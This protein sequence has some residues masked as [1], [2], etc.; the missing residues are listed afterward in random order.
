MSALHVLAPEI[1]L[2][3][4]CVVWHINRAGIY[5]QDARRRR[6]S[7]P[8]PPTPRSRAP[9]AFSESERQAQIGRAHV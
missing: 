8:R 2:A 4:A 9:L 1:G 6:L 3:P 7:S 5:R